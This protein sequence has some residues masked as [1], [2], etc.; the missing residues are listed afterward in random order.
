MRRI[1][2]AVAGMI[3]WTG[4]VAQAPTPPVAATATAID[5]AGPATWLCRPGVDDG[6]C[7]ADLDAVAIDARGARSPAPYIAAK[8]P[9]IDCFYVYPTV[10]LDPGTFSDMAPGPEERRTVH[11]QAA[12]LGS[13]CRLFV[14]VYRQLTITALRRE[15]ARADAGKAALDFDTPYRDILAAWRAYL[16]RDNKGRGVVL[17][18]H[19]QGAIILKQLLAEEIDGKP[20]QRRLVGAYLAG[21]PD[22]T[23]SSLR[24]IPPCRRLGATGCVT[25]WSSYRDADASRRV[26]GAGKPGDAA[27]CVNPAAPEGGRGMIEAYLPRPSLAPASDPPYVETIGQLSAECVADGAG[28]VLRIRIEPGAYAD[29]LGVAL[30]RMASAGGWGL[31]SLDINLVQ[32]N[33]VAMIAAQSAAW[34]RR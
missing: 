6:T 22:L 14:P 16:A 31:H 4:L 12:R 1:V 13:V 17:I 23:A 24:A 33:V 19:S 30:D 26:F 18:G 7:S 11:A 29:L 3:A 10:S 15:M 34:G 32:G 25:A 27:L 2:V 28:T 8:A 20:A 9:P 21:N 5:Y